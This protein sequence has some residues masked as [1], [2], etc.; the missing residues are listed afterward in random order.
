MHLGHGAWG[1]I[2]SCRYPQTNEPVP[3]VYLT[4]L[5]IDPQQVRF[6]FASHWHDDHIQGLAETL[7][8]CSDAEFGCSAAYTGP[9]FEALVLEYPK[10]IKSAPIQE[11]RRCFELIEK[12]PP[13]GPVH[14]TPTRI[15]E[16]SRVW[17]SDD[18]A[19][20]VVALA[21]TAQAIARAEN[22]IV[23]QLLP[24]AKK[25]RAFGRL[26]P[27][28]GSIV[29]AIELAADSVL[30]GGDLEE[31]RSG[32][33][34]WSAI[35]AHLGGS[36]RASSVFKVPH[37]GSAN[38]H[39]DGQWT[40]LLVEKPIAVCTTYSASRLPRLSDLDRL[41]RLSDS[42]F[43]AG[44]R[45]EYNVQLSRA[46]R[47]AMKNDQVTVERARDLGHVR[48]RQKM[49]AAAKGWSVELSEG[50]T[51]ITAAMVERRTQASTEQKRPR[52]RR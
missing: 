2:D 30:L 42:L 52:R 14:H 7:E 24:R 5:G 21:P 36:Y 38:A 13:E 49:P 1:V 29:V 26:T 15:V 46:E 23:T 17:A 16:R 28:Q 44:S 9:Q 11:M 4:R 6:I 25:R 48:L 33:S 18:S 50:A 34:G 45:D 32:G 27:N 51:S 47:H 39:Y 8:A 12:K 31:A 40:K 19:V 20:V 3:L 43:V 22:D 35:V 41:V 10:S 37:H